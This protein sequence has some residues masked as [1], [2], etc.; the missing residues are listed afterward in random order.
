[1]HTVLLLGTRREAQAL[2]LSRSTEIGCLQTDLTFGR[3]ATRRR[4][5]LAASG[6]VQTRGGKYAQEVRINSWINSRKN[7]AGRKDRLKESIVN[8][9]QEIDGAECVVERSSVRCDPLGDSHLSRVV[10]LLG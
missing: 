2:R 10:G 7:S 5:C 3:A 4:S 1:M 9:F 6:Q 8:R